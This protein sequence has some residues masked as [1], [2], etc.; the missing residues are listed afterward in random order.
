MRYKVYQLF[1]PGGVHLGDTSL[2]ESLVTFSADTLFSALFQE[3]LKQ[4]EDCAAWLYDT[5]VKGN[6][7][8]S[9]AF[10]Y[11]GDRFYLPKP[12]IRPEVIDDQG[13]SNQ[14]KAFKNLK[15][16]PMDLMED[17]LR[18]EL[19]AKKENSLLKQLSKRSLKTSAKISDGENTE[20]YHVGTLTYTAGNGLYIITATNAEEDEGKLYDLLDMLSFAGIGGKRMSG[21]GRFVISKEKKVD[22]SFFEKE[23]KWAMALNICLPAEDELDMA[24]E[25]ARYQV[26]KRGG[27]V[28]SETY[29]AQQR[30]KKDLYMFT[31][32]SCFRHR[33]KGEIFDVSDGGN[34]PV[35]RFGKP[36]F[37]TI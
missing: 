1:F 26:R 29:A 34:H 11:I 21:L 36:M 28:A 37:W 6:L 20:P 15:Y 18:G 16:I 12:M 3:A 24:M 4:G 25:G 14:K 9:D 13:D 23:G 5:A 31:A 35:Y 22:P 10:P 32:G 30:K 7:L 33:F 2:D 19:K 27:F 8:L 17:Y